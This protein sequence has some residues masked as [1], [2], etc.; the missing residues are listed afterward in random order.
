[1]LF[2]FWQYSFLAPNHCPN[3]YALRNET[4]G[5]IPIRF[6]YPANGIRG[7][8]DYSFVPSCHSDMYRK[9][10]KICGFLCRKSEAALDPGMAAVRGE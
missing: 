6:I 4:K 7:R 9:F 5:L 2:K 8:F 3:W 10:I 1:M